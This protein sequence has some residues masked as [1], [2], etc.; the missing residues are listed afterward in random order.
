MFMML[1]HIIWD[2]WRT[3]FFTFL[4]F[5]S[6]Y[7]AIIENRYPDS[8]LPVLKDLLSWWPWWL[9]LLFTLITFLVFTL[10]YANELR[11]Q[12]L[13][14]DDWIKSYYSKIG[15]YP[16]IPES[17]LPFVKSNYQKGQPITSNIKLRNPSLQEWKCLIPENKNRFIQLMHFLN[18]DS[19][20]FLQ[21]LENTRPLDDVN[22]MTLHR[23]K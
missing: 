14:N 15:K 4:S 13:E 12:L 20:E 2:K 1:R 17:L 23:K 6:F 5:A 10:L 16:P 9:W 11:L 3:P 19:T 7:S 21:V 22:G 8:K 18:L